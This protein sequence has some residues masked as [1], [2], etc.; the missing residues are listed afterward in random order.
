[1][2]ADALL[3]ALFNGLSGFVEFRR[4]PEGE[5]LFCSLPTEDLGVFAV[6]RFSSVRFLRDCYFGVATRRT[7]VN[8]KL[9][10]CGWLAALFV[11]IDFQTAPAHPN[12]LPEDQSRRLLSGFPLEPSIVVHTGGGL[13]V[14]WLLKAPCTSSE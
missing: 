8:G 10:N 1:M 3:N 6:A 9:E 12:T 13:H 2:S 14:Y 7:K 4:L 5:Q 11:D